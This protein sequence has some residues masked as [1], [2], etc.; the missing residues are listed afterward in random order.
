MQLKY[1]T[2]RE[3]KFVLMKIWWWLCLHPD[4]SKDNLPANLKEEGLISEKKEAAF[5]IFKIIRDWDISK[6]KTN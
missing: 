4:K 2:I 6:Y 3:A 1:E 5:N